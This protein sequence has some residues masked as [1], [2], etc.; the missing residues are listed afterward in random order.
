MKS[1]LNFLMTLLLLGCQKATV[2]KKVADGLSIEYTSKTVVINKPSNEVIVAVDEDG[3]VYTMKKSAF[4]HQPKAGEV[5]LIP[6]EM[7]RKVKRA[8]SSGE[9][10]EIETEEAVLTDV[11]ENGTIAFEI[12][13]EWV[14]ASSLRIE[15]REILTKGSR[16]SSSPIEFN[17]SVSGVDHKILI[18]PETKNGKINSCSFKFQMSKGN[19]TSFEAVGKATL[20]AQETLIYIEDGK[21]KEFKSQNNGL[22]ADF[23]V[24]MAT[25]GGESGEHSLSLPKIA[26]SIPIRFIPTAVGLVPNPIPMSIDVGVQFVSQMTIPDQMSSATAESVV[27]YSADGGF[28]YRDANVKTTGDLTKNEIK[29]GK[30]DAAANLGMPVDFQ[31]GIAFPRISFS[32]IVTLPKNRTS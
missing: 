27:N 7:L 12:T 32:V 10:F 13:P 2:E 28:E 4:T 16:L 31:F 15:G 19:S 21:L 26:V 5:V 3:V 6:G 30:F 8:H 9:N 1:I 29:D 23:K 14:D 20:P 22:D 25:A 17:R 18:E 24:R 11:I